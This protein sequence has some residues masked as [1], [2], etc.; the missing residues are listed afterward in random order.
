MREDFFF[1]KAFEH[2]LQWSFTTEEEGGL[3]GLIAGQ[4]LEFFRAIRNIEHYIF[5][6]VSFI[7]PTQQ[8]KER[9]ETTQSYEISL[10]I[11]NKKS[12]KLEQNVI[13]FSCT[14][15]RHLGQ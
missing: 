9:G 11:G 12:F 13:N 10:G 4:G 15:G 2:L 14:P 5:L 3:K 1:Y 8:A 6:V 7:L